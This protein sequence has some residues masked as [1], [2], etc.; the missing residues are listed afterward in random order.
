MIICV[1]HVIIIYCMKSGLFI[2]FVLDDRINKLLFV[3]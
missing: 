3:D 1:D 2:P